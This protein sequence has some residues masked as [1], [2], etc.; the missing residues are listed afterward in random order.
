MPGRAG[1]YVAIA[2]S[3]APLSPTCSGEAA[4][5]VKLTAAAIAKWMTKQ[6]G[7][8]TTAPKAVSVGGL[9]GVV[10]DVR[11]ADGWKKSCPY[12]NGA[13]MVPLIRGL[14][15]SDFDHSMI[16]GL[17]IRQYLLDDAGAVLGIE[18]DDVTGGSHLDQY[19]DVVDTF[20]FAP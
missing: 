14:A 7:L 4:A 9:K 13:P 8:K 17:A 20:R 12:A 11:L 19:S 2:A 15:P 6:P 16:P 10:L 5:G 1:D 18:V 3:V